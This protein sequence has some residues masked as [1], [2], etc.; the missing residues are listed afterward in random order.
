[1]SVDESASAAGPRG[2]G[3]Q[4]A[5]VDLH[6]VDATDADLHDVDQDTDRPE[7]DYWADDESD[8]GELPFVPRP[9]YRRNRYAGLAV[10]VLAYLV[11]LLA[12]FLLGED[13]RRWLISFGA[14]AL[15]LTAGLAVAAAVLL[16]PNRTHSF[17][18]GLLLSIAAATLI[19]CA[20]L[21]L[22]GL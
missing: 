4:R 13:G 17:A 12:A 8:T 5:E 6:A 15:V 18:V 3:I 9:R 7:F 14:W 1:M 10:G 11:T 20:A 16:G 19:G 2:T 22:G 21:S